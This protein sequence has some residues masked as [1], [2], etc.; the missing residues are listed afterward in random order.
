MDPTTAIRDARQRPAFAL[1]ASSSWTYPNLPTFIMPRGLLLAPLLLL[2]PSSAM[3]FR[4]PCSTG[5]LLRAVTPP[6]PVM[7]AK[8]SSRREARRAA[9][10][11]EELGGAAA[12]EAAAAPAPAVDGPIMG[13]QEQNLV[14]SFVQA[15]PACASRLTP[16]L[17]LPS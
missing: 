10:A 2:L 9:K 1:E 5:G 16:R 15:L 17:L 12:P 7:M 14:S 11:R 6:S 4:P 13:A 3:V 8:R